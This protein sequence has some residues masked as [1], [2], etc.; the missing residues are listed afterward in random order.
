[1]T[2]KLPRLNWHI[3]AGFV[4]TVVAFLSYFLFFVMFPLTRDFPWVNLVL[5]VTAGV[6]VFI[7]VRR[8]FAAGRSR[9]AKVAG[10]VLA[11]LSILIF[12]FFVH[13]L[14]VRAT[15]LPASA[16]AP[17]VG[18]QAPEFSLADQGG[19]HVSLSEL[20]SNPINGTAPRG[21][22]LVFYRGYW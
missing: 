21:V 3:W 9:L 18:Q 4:L 11:A 8:A 6:L 20:L 22:L 5:F 17:K 7:G 1:M 13:I 19:K 15:Q 14:F 16:R 12:A 10:S 2:E